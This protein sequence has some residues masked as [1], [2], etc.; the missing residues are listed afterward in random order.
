MSFWISAL[1]HI[2][3]ITTSV[4]LC[5]LVLRD[6]LRY[7]LLYPL[8][9]AACRP[10]RSADGKILAFMGISIY[11]PASTIVVECPCMSLR[12]LMWIYI[13]ASHCSATFQRGRWFWDQCLRGGNPLLLFP[14][15]ICLICACRKLQVGHPC[16]FRL[17]FAVSLVQQIMRH[18]IVVRT[19]QSSMVGR[20]PLARIWRT[21][22]RKWSI[23]QVW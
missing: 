2:S 9:V 1:L 3:S 12:A 11:S 16:W 19:F 13:V 14:T 10:P 23:S 8:P 20:G 17:I 18:T 21:C 6:F 4:G 5:P 15:K 22:E 7:P